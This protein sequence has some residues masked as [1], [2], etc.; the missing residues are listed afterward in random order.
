MR[1]KM[2]VANGS[3]VYT[4]K[5]EEDT[6]EQVVALLKNPDVISITITKQTPTECFK[7]IRKEKTH[8]TDY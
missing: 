3:A 6:I 7:S 4:M 8:G 2:Q 1:I 5:G